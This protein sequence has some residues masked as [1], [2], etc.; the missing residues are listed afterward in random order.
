MRNHFSIICHASWRETPALTARMK[1]LPLFFVLIWERLAQME[2]IVFG[3]D[4]GFWVFFCLSSRTQEEISATAAP[5]VSKV[6]IGIFLET[7]EYGD[8][9]S[10]RAN[11]D[12]HRV[13]K[14][15]QN[16]KKTLSGPRRSSHVAHNPPGKLCN[17][18]PLC[19]VTP[20]CD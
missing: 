2:T 18:S 6:R 15:K 20:A 13:T 4:E 19:R 1:Y 14:L 12:P 7:G 17:Q 9:Q 10:E 16:K 8:A 3:V 11:P 5:A